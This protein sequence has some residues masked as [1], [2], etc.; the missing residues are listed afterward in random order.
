[1]RTGFVTF[2]TFLVAQNGPMVVLGGPE[3]VQRSELSRVMPLGIVLRKTRGVT[4]WTPWVWSAVAVLPGAG[5]ADWRVLRR[6]G[7]AEE[8]HAAT[9]PLEIHRAETEAYRHGLSVGVPSV[10]V[11][12]RLLTGA[13]CPLEVVLAT[14]SPYEAQ[15]YADNG[16]D[17][18]EKVPMPASLAAWIG[19]FIETHH[20]DEVFVKRRRDVARVDLHED[21]VGDPRIDKPA[22]IYAAPGQR[23][24]LQ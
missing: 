24:R 21:G 14:A 13:P 16:E 1:M 5:P 4:R 3:K 2:I 18:V 10:Y 12:M 11:I 8:V 19:D 22:N 6:E 9:V 20:E 7:E 23:R 15:D 17:L